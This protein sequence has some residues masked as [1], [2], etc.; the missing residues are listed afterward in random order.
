MNIISNEFFSSLTDVR[1]WNRFNE[2]EVIRVVVVSAVLLFLPNLLNIILFCCKEKRRTFKFLSKATEVI[3]PF[4]S[5]LIITLFFKNLFEAVF[6][7]KA[8]PN[9]EIILLNSSPIL[10][11]TSVLL[12]VS[13][14]YLCYSMCCKKG[15]EEYEAISFSFEDYSAN[16][17]GSIPLSRFSNKKV[18]CLN[19]MRGEI[20]FNGNYLAMIYLSLTFFHGFNTGLGFNGNEFINWYNMIIYLYKLIEFFRLR[21][22]IKKL[23]YKKI[24]TFFLIFMFSLATPIGIVLRGIFTDFGSSDKSH[25]SDICDNF[26]IGSSFVMALVELGTPY[27]RKYPELAVNFCLTFL[28]ALFF[29]FWFFWKIHF[30]TLFKNYF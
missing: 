9:L 17:R 6:D 22:A 13:L 20:G 21:Q 16:F 28:T 1:V 15:N 7:F 5:G 12:L 26:F 23:N 14:V 2:I 25:I 4:V 24:T 10:F 29:S 11:L 18:G 8:L 3:R 19:Y 27:P 30:L